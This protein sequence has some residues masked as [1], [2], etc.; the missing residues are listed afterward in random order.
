MSEITQNFVVEPNNINITV[1]TNNINFTPTD[2]QL[3]IFTSAPGVAGGSNTQLQFNNNNEFGGI[4]N[5]T[6]NGS[7]LSLGNVS[8][9][10]ITGGT[11]GF[12][13]QTDGTGNLNWTAQTG[14]GGGN[15][16]PGGANTQIQYNDSG[17]FG[18]NVGFTFN[19]VSGNV[20]IPNNLTSNTLTGNIITASQPNITT[21]GTLT[22]LVVNGNALINSTLSINGGIEKTTLDSL[23]PAAN[24]NFDLIDQ[25]IIYSTANATTDTTLNFRGSFGI[26][27]NSYLILGDSTIGTYVVTTGTTAYGI[28]NI[29]IDSTAQTIKWINGSPPIAL[30]NSVTAYTFTII[31]TS[32]SPT[33]TVLGTGARYA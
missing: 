4:P 1:D 30:S 20:N 31:K 29:Q 9:V 13:L 18:G 3:G 28:T 24:V 12:V 21:V 7:N 33:Y 22:N 17:S 32:N 15:G 5:V 25:A 6:W 11:N 10:K 14:G 16:V 27:A 8:N 19:E 26:T 2:I 23:A